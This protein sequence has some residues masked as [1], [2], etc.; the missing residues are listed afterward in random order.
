MQGMRRARVAA[1]TAEGNGVV[2]RE[3][4]MT[5]QEL[6]ELFGRNAYTVREWIRQEGLPDA[7][8]WLHV[9]WRC[10]SETFRFRVRKEA[11]RWL[12]DRQSVRMNG[13]VPRSR[14]T[15]LEQMADRLA[16]LEEAYRRLADAWEQRN[17]G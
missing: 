4:T 10:R 13:A 14:K 3:G 12:V 1:I 15:P 7:D 8:G 5:L 17:A 16:S 6:G 2:G 9:F 11:G